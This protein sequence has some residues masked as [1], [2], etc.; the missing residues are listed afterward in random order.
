MLDGFGLINM[1]GRMYDPVIGRVLSPDPSVQSPTY[2]Q[3]YNRYSYCLNNPLRYTDPSGYF[4]HPTDWRDEPVILAPYFGDG[5][6]GAIGPGSGNFWSDPY[7]SEYGN[8]MLGSESSFNKMYG[9]GAYSRSKK[10]ALIDK[11]NPNRDELYT[12]GVIAKI[13]PLK[14][15]E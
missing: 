6:A 3:N 13:P 7:R 4:V 11:V 10:D 5:V 9:P 14:Q 2:T 1:N 12:N 8:F 15:D